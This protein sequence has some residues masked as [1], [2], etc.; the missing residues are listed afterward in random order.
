[1]PLEITNKP[2]INAPTDS[3]SVSPD[4]AALKALTERTEK[5]IKLLDQRIVAS[6]KN[7]KTDNG[8]LDS[9]FGTKDAQLANADNEQKFIK[10]M[11]EQRLALTK[12]LEEAKNLKPQEAKTLLETS[13][14]QDQDSTKHSVK[15]FQLE[16][17]RVDMALDES[18][19]KIKTAEAATRTVRNAAII[20]GAA[21][22]TVMTAGAGAGLTAAWSASATAQG[23]AA[24]WAVGTT[25]GMLTSSV[26]AETNVHLGNQTREQ[27]WLDA[28]EQTKQYSTDSFKSAAATAGGGYLASRAVAGLT[29]KAVAQAG[30]GSMATSTYDT[31]TAIW[32]ADQD[33][34]KQYAD[35]IKNSTREEFK[36]LKEKFFEERGLDAASI[37]KSFGINTLSGM[38]SAAVGSKIPNPMDKAAQSTSQ[39]A[40][41]SRGLGLMAADATAGATVGL[42]AATANDEGL[43]T[44]NIEEQLVSNIT[45]TITGNLSPNSRLNPKI[46]VIENPNLPAGVTSRT[47]SIA[48]PGKKYPHEAI[49]EVDP[50]LS[51]EKRK[52]VFAEELEHAKYTIS[53]LTIINN[54]KAHSVAMLARELRAKGNIKDAERVMHYTRSGQLDEAIAFS[55]TKLGSDYVRKYLDDAQNLVHIG[56]NG[57]RRQI[58]YNLDDNGRAA[59]DLVE[60]CIKAGNQA[61]AEDLLNGQPN[62]LRDYGYSLDAG[63]KLVID[64]GQRVVQALH[65]KSPEQITAL[66]NDSVNCGSFHEL[67]NLYGYKLD[68]TGA[69]KISTGLS[70][71]IPSDIKVLQQK[72]EWLDHANATT[73]DKDYWDAYKSNLVR[74]DVDPT[75]FTAKI[76]QAKAIPASMSLSERITLAK[77]LADIQ[78]KYTSEGGTTALNRINTL[79]DDSN[80]LGLDQ[81]KTI[82]ELTEA[83]KANDPPYLRVGHITAGEV[84]LNIRRNPLYT[85]LLANQRTIIGGNTLISSTGPVDLALIPLASNGDYQGFSIGANHTLLRHGKPVTTNINEQ[86]KNIPV[87]INDQAGTRVLTA[88]QQ[89]VIICESDSRAFISREID[90][91]ADA[92]TDSTITKRYIEIKNSVD[93]LTKDPSDYYGQLEAL[94][95]ISRANGAQPCISI[96]SRA[97]AK[98]QERDKIKLQ[99]FLIKFHHLAQGL[100]LNTVKPNERLTILDEH[101]SDISRSIY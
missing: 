52:Q 91:I 69:L 99:D 76:A 2:I 61:G 35:E 57:E 67:I 94:I 12:A 17:Q 30:L 77:N 47:T 1:M 10:S 50:K 9:F 4:E 93:V 29:A 38:A 63:N 23:V 100:G 54:P 66:L 80:H 55:E 28:A 71:Q 75:L 5:R 73:S 7:L 6:Q 32:Q 78:Q 53:D 87:T 49:I 74:S 79:I 85:N 65:S 33:F 60:A 64:H 41:I 42:V 83:V 39:L 44:Q 11:Q 101:G 88:N 70:T 90:L 58:A 86:I 31:G 25:A 81:S 45:S 15:K 18:I 51:P 98:D 89:P 21:A 8:I 95:K 43:T 19:A 40:N 92:K 72:R 14:K 16:T 24:G 97:T 48:K 82:K 27:A 34:T 22:V 96:P 20:G 59:L 13:L 84:L 46:T 26:E 3:S 68:T 62:L 37:S 36:T 56:P